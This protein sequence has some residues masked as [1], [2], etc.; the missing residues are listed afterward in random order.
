[1]K[2]Y[3]IQSA[4][5]F[6]H[7]LHNSYIEMEDGSILDKCDYSKIK[8]A[9]SIP[10]SK[11]TSIMLFSSWEILGKYNEY[12][13]DNDYCIDKIEKPDLDESQFRKVYDNILTLEEDVI[14]IKNI[15]KC[16]K[17]RLSIIN[18]CNYKNN[19]RFKLNLKNLYNI[20]D[21]VISN[22]LTISKEVLFKINSFL[23]SLTLNEMKK[24]LNYNLKKTPKTFQEI[25]ILFSL[26][27]K[28][29]IIGDEMGL[30][31]SIQAIATVNIAKAYP[32]LIVCP[33]S[34]KYNWRDE[35]NESSYSNS[36][37]LNGK[38]PTDKDFY[39][40]NYESIHKHLKFIKE[41]GFKSIIFDE[42]HYLKNEDA[43][44]TKNSLEIVKNIEYRIQLTGTPV[45]K[46]PL[47]LV[48]QL[49]LIN[50]LDFFGGKEHFL[51][52]YCKP[53]KTSFG[54]DYTGASNLENL[55]NKLR[56]ICFIRRTKKEVL[57]E[58][59]EKTRTKILVDIPN[60]TEYKR[61][62]KDFLSLDRNNKLNKIDEF[63]QAVAEYKLP[64]VKE[65]IDGFIANNQKIVVFA[66]H[67]SIQNK[68]IEM[69][70]NACKIISEESALQDENKKCFQEDDSKQIIICS[71][72]IA[73][74]GLDL[75]AASNVIFTEMD[76]CPALNNQA[77]D[78]CHRIGQMSAV[79]AWYII[80][81][82]TIEEHIWNVSE[83][84]RKVIE[85]IYLRKTPEKEESFNIYESIIEE[86]IASLE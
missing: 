15:S 32:C 55:S 60:I 74:I 46:I 36:H 21:S 65:I 48:S 43:K 24:G 14:Y 11:W 64:L 57:K 78:R 53:E 4:I 45:L 17:E 13:K 18:D 70:P 81:K 19:Y 34:L 82:D 22:E 77:E 12:L 7:E 42:S 16:M 25:G 52:N 49:K 56:E 28:K 54:T 10:D 80:A 40:I 68:L 79:N 66:Y 76:W 62:L 59:P 63:R 75:T 31:K 5:K 26:L 20:L 2:K 73:N 30:G 86:V 84:K 58:L 41:N 27:N 47:D 69:Y 44:R 29:I 37:F 23:N 9:T 83:R 61:T 39:I 85:Q 67:R 6:L 50:K 1:M 35:I 33:A 3:P 71:F 72:K 8:A 51:E 38:N